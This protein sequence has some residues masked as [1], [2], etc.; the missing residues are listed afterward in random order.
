MMDESPL[1]K[2]RAV[3]RAKKA[4]QE[5]LIEQLQRQVAALISERKAPEAPKQVEMVPYK[6]YVRAKQDCYINGRYYAG[7][8]RYGTSEASVFEVDMPALWSDDP[9]EPVLITG[10]RDHDNSP[11]VAPNPSA[12]TPIDA[13]LRQANRDVYAPAIRSM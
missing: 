2:A 6:G 11:I 10:Y 8:D 12:P 4:A 1:I 5:A 3:K 7:A 13:R 9:F